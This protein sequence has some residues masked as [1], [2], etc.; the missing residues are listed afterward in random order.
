MVF[1][2][3]NIENMGPIWRKTL[4]TMK[5]LYS[6]SELWVHTNQKFIELRVVPT[7]FKGNRIR[8]ST[9]QANTLTHLQKLTIVLYNHIASR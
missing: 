4:R 3:E 1:V 5:F 8:D 6:K 9:S 2:I 7:H